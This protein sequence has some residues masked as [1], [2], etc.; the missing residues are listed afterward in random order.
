MIFLMRLFIAAF[1]GYLATFIT[2]WLLHKVGF[3]KTG[4]RPA[5]LAAYLQSRH[6]GA[7]PKNGYFAA[8]QQWGM[9]GAPTFVSVIV[10]IIAAR[11]VLGIV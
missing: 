5:T 1:L 10:F 4:V 8:L 6:K 11:V 2:P 3:G 9:A 7:I